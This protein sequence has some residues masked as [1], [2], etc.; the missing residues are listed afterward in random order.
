MS[1][2][3]SGELKILGGENYMKKIGLILVIMLLY[4]AAWA[5]SSAKDS[6]RMGEQTQQ[7]AA[8]RRR[9][10]AQQTHERA[11]GPAPPSTPYIIYP[12][13]SKNK[14]AHY[15]RCKDCPE[16]EFVVIYP[17]PIPVESAWLDS[18]SYSDSLTWDKK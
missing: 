12:D 5:Q 11:R 16:P 3:L 17:P 15:H 1:L 14:H 9:D 18:S 2:E 13:T 8:A 7:E 10:L 6:I 4:D